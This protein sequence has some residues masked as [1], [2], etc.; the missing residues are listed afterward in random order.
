MIQTKEDIAKKLKTLK[1]SD[2]KIKAVAS[3]AYFMG[4]AFEGDPRDHYEPVKV[5]EVKGMDD[6]Q[7]IGEACYHALEKMAS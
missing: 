4:N 6:R 3:M 2:G 7:K 5:T 1:G